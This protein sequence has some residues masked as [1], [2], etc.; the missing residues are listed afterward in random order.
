MLYSRACS[1]DFGNLHNYLLD[2]K[3][4]ESHPRC[5]KALTTSSVSGHES[6]ATCVQPPC[7][8]SAGLGAAQS[9]WVGEDLLNVVIWG[10][11]EN[12]PEL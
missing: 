7:I 11:G 5:Y 1:F 8:L 12:G 9:G 2:S 4:I 10:G 3:P 6:A